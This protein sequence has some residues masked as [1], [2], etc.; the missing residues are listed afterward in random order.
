MAVKGILSTATFKPFSYEEMLAPVLSATQAQLAQEEALT[1]LYE[2]ASTMEAIIGSDPNSKSAEKYNKYKK[3][4]QEEIDS[5]MSK[6][7]NINSRK[8]LSKL[9]GEYRS[10]I[11][12]IETAYKR[13]AED[14]KDFNKSELGKDPTYIG[15]RPQDLSIDDYLGGN[16]PFVQGV[17]GGKIEAE[18]IALAQALASRVFRYDRD[19]S[20][21]GY[22]L[23]RQGLNQDEVMTVLNAIK[24]GEELKDKE[25][26]GIVKTLKHDVIPEIE[27]LYGKSNY[28][29][30]D[31]TAFESA[32]NSGLYKGLLAK[33]SR[34]KDEKWFLD[35]KF[36]QDR[37]NAEY[38]LSKNKDLEKYKHDLQL[39]E[40]A[41]KEGLKNG[42]LVL[43]GNKI[44]PANPVDGN[45]DDIAT[46]F[47]P[48]QDYIGSN[49]TEFLKLIDKLGIPL[50]GRDIDYNQLSAIIDEELQYYRDYYDELVRLQNAKKANMDDTNQE[51]KLQRIT[52]SQKAIRDF[53]AKHKRE[54]KLSQKEYARLNEILKVSKPERVE[55][56]PILFNDIMEA[57]INNPSVIKY[58]YT[59]L[60]LARKEFNKSAISGLAQDIV[61][62]MLGNPDK[63]ARVLDVSEGFEN[64]EPVSKDTDR[65]EM[66]TSLSKGIQSISSSPELILGDL[67]NNKESY[68][69]VITTDGKIFLVPISFIDNAA[70]GLLNNYKSTYSKHFNSIRLPGVNR[71]K[72][73]IDV[74]LNRI[75]K[76]IRKYYEGAKSKDITHTKTDNE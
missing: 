17:S 12:P 64:A 76:N 67:F 28:K 59:P 5:I 43:E 69:N 60:Y 19:P 55:N 63:Q 72:S 70:L 34:V 20:M 2:D 75:F 1:K 11:T 18:S 23:E 15:M 37:S 21:P 62:A 50:D 7:I 41:I 14:I 6:G 54:P 38:A 40:F 53:Y 46:S 68:L 58:S 32:I 71:D 42:T 56:S 9:R 45:D 22:I 48:S 27:R 49:N 39:Q 44:V 26:N 52:E 3:A 35:Y 73:S 30:A 57:T 51:G 29:N 74:N 25:L 4:L 66:I 10:E 33:E 65:E 47:G 31:I 61:T 13:R 36:N 16:E 8:N 24:T